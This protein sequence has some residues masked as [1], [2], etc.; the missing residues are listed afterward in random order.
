MTGQIDAITFD[1]YRVWTS[2]GYK[3]IF[4]SEAKPIGEATEQAK[5][6]PTKEENYRWNH[7]LL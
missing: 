6:D 5:K 3:W 1:R 7:F 2:D 4:Q